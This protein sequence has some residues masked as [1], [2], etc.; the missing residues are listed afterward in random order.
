V[1]V[2]STHVRFERE[3]TS[4]AFS[5]D[6]A[7]CDRVAF[8]AEGAELLVHESTWSLTLK[9]ETGHGHS[10]AADAGQVAALAKAKRLALVHTARE[11]AGHDREIE[12]EAAAHF[13]G[14]VTAPTDFTTIEV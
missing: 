10:T 3:G 5:G 11:L 12:A 8:N 13:G 14:E 4:L 1:P 7:L 9:T 6:T 2:I